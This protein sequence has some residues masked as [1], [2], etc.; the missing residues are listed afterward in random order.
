MLSERSL[1]EEKTM[2]SYLDEVIESFRRCRR[3]KKFLQT[4]YDVFLSKSPEIASKFTGTNFKL[5]KL[6]LRESLLMVLAFH[7]SMTGAREE[8]VDLGARHR[9]L[10]VTPE[11]YSMWLD[12]LCEAISRHDPQFTTELEGKWRGALREPIELMIGEREI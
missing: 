10:G 11:H 12:A 3:D 6:L 2:G 4:F 9:S 7:L 5:Q 8:I 1:H